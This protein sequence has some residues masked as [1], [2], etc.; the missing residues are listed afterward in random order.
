[1]AQGADHFYRDHE[2]ELAKV[3]ADWLDALLPAP[4]K[5][6]SR[7]WWSRREKTN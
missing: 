7:R 3:V 5:A 1:M 4:Q 2:G 6:M